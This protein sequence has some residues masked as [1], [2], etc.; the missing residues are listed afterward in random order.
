M[1]ALLCLQFRAPLAAIEELGQLGLETQADEELMS[2]LDSAEKR[3]PWHPVPHIIRAA[4]L[5]AELTRSPGWDENLFRSICAAYEKAMALDPYEPTIALKL[6][7]VQV[8]AERT[9]AALHTARIAME[10]TPGSVDLLTWVYFH[11]TTHNQTQTAAEM[12]DRSL[13]LE[14][15]AARWWR[16]RFWFEQAEGRGPSATVALN[17]ALTAAVGKPEQAEAETIQTYFERSEGKL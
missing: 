16:N 7:E 4:W 3:L 2:R 10:R 11:A 13:Y 17:V 15:E 12:I 5:R 9:D 1:L 8:I 6:A 14:P